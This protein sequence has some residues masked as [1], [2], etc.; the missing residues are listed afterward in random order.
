MPA[1]R[2][3]ILVT[4]ATGLIGSALVRRLLADG[5]S[6]VALV[7]DEAKARRLL[8]ETVELVVGDVTSPWTV[9]GP[10]DF[11]VHA[12]S[13]TS[14]A[15]FAGHPV[16]TIATAVDGTRRALELAREKAVKKFVY[17]SSME[18]YGTGPDDRPIGE[19]AGST[20]DVQSPRASYPESKRLCESL[21]AA[22]ASEYG[23]PACILRLAQTFGPGVARDDSRVIAEFVRRA[24]AHEPII[25]KTSGES[26]RQCLDIEDAV[27]AILVLLDRGEP[28]C[29]YNAGNPET[30]CSIAET[31]DLISRLLNGAGVRVEQAPVAETAKY[32]PTYSLNLD[33]SRLVALGWRPQYGLVEICRRMAESWLEAH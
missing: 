4:G 17:L 8:G 28:G 29:A 10:V 32:P 21:C 33:V 19:S 31:A 3:R 6:V 11:I 27:A 9:E 2:R 20:W 23:V 25:L 15:F 26:R 30:Y 13:P 24:M 16:E 7:R 18:V 22:F 12:A 14:S 1:E 5:A